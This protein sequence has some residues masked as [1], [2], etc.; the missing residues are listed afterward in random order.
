MKDKKRIIRVLYILKFIA[1]VILLMVAVRL[2]IAQNYHVVSADM[3]DTLMQGDIVLV[4]KLAYSY[5][6]INSGDIIVFNHPYMVGRKIIRRVVAVEGQMLEIKD[7]LLY[8]DS[9]PVPDYLGIKYDDENIFPK[10]YSLRDNFGPIQIPSGYVFV[11]SDNRDSGDDSRMWGGV[12]IKQITGK[13]KIVLF[14]WD[15]GPDSPVFESPYITPLLK[16]FWHNI[17]HFYER[18]DWSRVGVSC[19]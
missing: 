5:A 2:F 12:G 11:M 4:S 9:K 18:I 19:S 13:A 6:S 7:K 1:I 3:G 15:P 14:N 16:I 8:V 17:I 10:E